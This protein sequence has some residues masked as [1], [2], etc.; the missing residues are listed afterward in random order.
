MTRERSEPGAP[1]NTAF[2]HDH[3]VIAARKQYRADLKA[4]VPERQAWTRA[5]AAYTAVREEIAR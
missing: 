5:D 2:H 1:R 4:G 3:R